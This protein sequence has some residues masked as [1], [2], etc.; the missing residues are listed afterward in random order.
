MEKNRFD[1][2]KLIALI[3]LL[4]SSLIVVSVMFAITYFNDVK[5]D[6][7]R[8]DVKRCYIKESPSTLSPNT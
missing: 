5:H 1:D 8:L 6:D 2:N 3:A 7:A 4:A